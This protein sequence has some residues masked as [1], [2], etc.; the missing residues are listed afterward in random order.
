MKLPGRKAKRAKPGEYVLASKFPDCDPHDPWRVGYVCQVIETW[1]L[2]GT[3][4]LP[5]SYVI[6]EADG[7]WSDKYQY[8]CCR[9]ITAEEG[10]EWI[11][12]HRTDPKEI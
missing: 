4:R 1:W 11:A 12:L 7:T 8:R 9:R 5:F 10:D 2:K 3:L 6:G